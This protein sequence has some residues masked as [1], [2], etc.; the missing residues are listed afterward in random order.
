[1]HD[2]NSRTAAARVGLQR[3]REVHRQ[4]ILL[5]LSR[6]PGGLTDAELCRFTKLTPRVIQARRGE[7]YRDGMVRAIATVKNVTTWQLV[8]DVEVDA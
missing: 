5:W 3:I 6:C 7:L 2:P 1:M 4:R 8:V